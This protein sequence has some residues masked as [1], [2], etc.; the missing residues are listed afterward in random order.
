MINVLCPID[1]LSRI[2]VLSPIN[3]L[4]RVDV[5]SVIDV[6]NLNDVSS[7]INMVDQKLSSASGWTSM[8]I[9][10]AIYNLQFH[11]HWKGF[12]QSNF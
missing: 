3:M 12:N 8:F 5:L 10:I 11:F 6:L 9:H 1:M 4:S 2:D 7:L